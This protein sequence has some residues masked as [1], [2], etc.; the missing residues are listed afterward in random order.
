MS[1]LCRSFFVTFTEH[2]T[3]RTS[4]HMILDMARTTPPPTM[5]RSVPKPSDVPSMVRTVR[6]P[7]PP[8]QTFNATLHT[9]DF[10]RDKL[11][12]L[13]EKAYAMAMAGDVHAM[14]LCM[15]RIAPVV[16]ER[17]MPPVDI[18]RVSSIKDVPRAMERV[19]AAMSEGTLTPTEGQVAI[20]V[21]K[22]IS[23]TLQSLQSDTRLSNPGEF[24]AK[25]RQADVD[26]DM[27]SAGGA[28]G[29]K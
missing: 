29:E 28:H 2:L 19:L 17:P 18:G 15:D 14:R 21:M 20:T 1:E 27:L 6:R 10:F 24:A 23:D 5:Q 9:F 4:A 8:S 3:N 13:L 7:H 26:I 25:L 22:T 16:K 12:D 11:D